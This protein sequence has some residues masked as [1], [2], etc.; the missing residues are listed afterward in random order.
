[1]QITSSEIDRVR[2]HERKSDELQRTRKLGVGDV[3]RRRRVQRHGLSAFSLRAGSGRR[4]ASISG[5]I[6][7]REGAKLGRTVLKNL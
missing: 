3:S 4:K 7:R 1:V 5:N 2:D 6:M